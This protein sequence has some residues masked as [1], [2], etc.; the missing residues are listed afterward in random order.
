MRAR[1][2]RRRACRGRAPARRDPLERAPPIRDRGAVALGER[3]LERTLERRPARPRARR[4]R[5]RGDVPQAAAQPSPGRSEQGAGSEH[6]EHDREPLGA[7]ARGDGRKLGLAGTPAVLDVRG[8]HARRHLD[9]EPVREVATPGAVAEAVAHRAGLELRDTA[10]PRR[11]AA[12]R[13][14]RSGKRNTTWA[15]SPLTVRSTVGSP[16]ASYGVKSVWSRI[17]SG[18]TMRASATTSAVA[19]TGAPKATT[20]GV[21]LV[22]T[23]IALDGDPPSLSPRTASQNS[24]TASPTTTAAVTWR[25]ITAARFTP[26]C[27][28][29]ACRSADQVRN[30]SKM[31]SG[32]S[33]PT[34]TGSTPSE[35]RLTTK[36]E[37]RSSWR[38][39]HA[40]DSPGA[41]RTGRTRPSVPTSGTT[42]RSTSGNLLPH[43]I[44]NDHRDDVPPRSSAH[45]HVS[46]RVGS[47]KS[48][49]TKTKLADGNWRRWS[50]RNSNIVVMASAP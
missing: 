2:P 5:A 36:L 42:I 3:E 9:E 20:L 33:R 49:R 44:L 46:G 38:S 4:T 17:D 19:T 47:M 24:R 32:S 37:S 8:T 10:R 22:V 45:S 43:R 21:T 6:E 25:T 30:A 15:V 7:E 18:R 40:C 27:P 1:A 34:T 13:R 39:R 12:S 41:S 23:A 28:H 14:Q 50:V 26:A 29:A 16:A 48:E 35:R 11:V 31:C